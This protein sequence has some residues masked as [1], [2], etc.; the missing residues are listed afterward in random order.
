M[1]LYLTIYQDLS[2]RLPGIMSRSLI[3][4]RHYYTEKMD[5]HYRKKTSLHHIK[6]A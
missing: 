1:Y 3:F 4:C 5:L 2:A 6:K